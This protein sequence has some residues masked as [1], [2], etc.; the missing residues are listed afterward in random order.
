MVCPAYSSVCAAIEPR[1]REALAVDMAEEDLG[2]GDRPIGPERVRHAM[3]AEGHLVE[4]ALEFKAG[5]VNEALILRV[6]G[7]LVLVEVSV[8]AQR[9]EVEIENAVGFRKQPRGLG[10]GLASQ[11]RGQRQQQENEQNNDD[12]RL[13]APGHARYGIPPSSWRNH[14]TRATSG[15][16][17][18]VRGPGASQLR[19][20]IPPVVTLAIVNLLRDLVGLLW[21]G[22][23]AV[24][25]GVAQ[26][27]EHL[28][29][30]QTVGGSSPF[31]SSRVSFAG[32]GIPP[33][34]FHFDVLFPLTWLRGK[35]S[36]E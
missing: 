18:A 9:A 19:Q 32:T 4:V 1:W 2:E 21:A 12:G 35:A 28:I 25:A 14:S 34:S 6:V 23:T 7:H 29:C 16:A 22:S 26:L 13:G 8:G 31:A 5:S 30:N 27:V 36:A 20:H 3:E 10:R 24:R 11:V 15:T 33:Q 17:V